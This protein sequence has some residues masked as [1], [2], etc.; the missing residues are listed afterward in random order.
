MGYTFA[1]FDALPTSR[2]DTPLLDAVNNGRKLS[3]FDERELL[4]LALIGGILYGF[5]ASGL[6]RSQPPPERSLR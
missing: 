4:A 5:R 6:A 2:P 1:M 3:E